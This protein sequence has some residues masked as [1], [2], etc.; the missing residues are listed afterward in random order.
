V[1][2]QYNVDIPALSRVQV[3]RKC[4]F[5]LH[6]HDWFGLMESIILLYHATL[7]LLFK[8]RSGGW[9]APAATSGMAYRKFSRLQ[10]QLLPV[11]A[12]I[13]DIFSTTRRCARVPSKLLMTRSTRWQN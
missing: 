11:Q 4:V 7:K 3:K 9:P 8:Q 5:I 6:E 2:R 10:L 1:A 13:A 12:M